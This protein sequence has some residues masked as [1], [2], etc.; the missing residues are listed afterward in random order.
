MK[1]DFQYLGQWIGFDCN[2]L[3]VL[4]FFVVLFCGFVC[5]FFVFVF[6]FYLVGQR[7][8]GREDTRS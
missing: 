1:E 8:A 4:G 6:V 3:F 7:A 2:I 5:G